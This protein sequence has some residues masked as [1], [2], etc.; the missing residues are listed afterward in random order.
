MRFLDENWYRS[1]QLR[2][3][4]RDFTVD[5]RVSTDPRGLREEVLPKWYLR[6]FRW[7]LAGREGEY[8]PP[9]DADVRD[10][11]ERYVEDRVE[12]LRRT[13]PDVVPMV[14]EP[15]LFAFG[16]VTEAQYAAIE[17]VSKY[18]GRVYDERV[19]LHREL[20]EACMPMMGRRMRYFGMHDASVSVTREGRNILMEC[21][22]SL[23]IPDLIVFENALVV[24]GRLPERF[25]GLYQETFW[26]DGRYEVGFLADGEGGVIEFTITADN[27]R[28]YNNAGVEITDDYDNDMFYARNRLT[29]RGGQRIWERDP[30]NRTYRRTGPVKVGAT[31]LY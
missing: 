2:G 3:C 24:Q 29:H 5:R 20:T 23:S 21:S 13:F 1:M 10:R 9:V 27:I 17:G 19:R 4:E 15:D 30:E 8:D 31:R 18:W 16:Y 14:S 26:T 7:L 12:Q 25:S 6:A 22:R 28:M 11:L